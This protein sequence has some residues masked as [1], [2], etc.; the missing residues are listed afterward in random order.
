[1]MVSPP[2][3]AAASQDASQPERVTAD[4]LIRKLQLLTGPEKKV[5]AE[6][7]RGA[8]VKMWREKAKPE[9]RGKA[10]PGIIDQQCMT[11]IPDLLQ[12]R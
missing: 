8:L 12:A 1:M 6:E 10:F 4:G 5:C 2:G 9:K 7:S 3:A 11:G